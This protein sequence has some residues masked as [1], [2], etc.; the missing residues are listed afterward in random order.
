MEGE[1]SD[2]QSTETTSPRRPLTDHGDIQCPKESDNQRLHDLMKI[3][4][5]LINSV[6][7]GPKE[8]DQNQEQNVV[9]VR[10]VK[11]RGYDSDSSSSDS[12]SAQVGLLY[13]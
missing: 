9:R 6:G 2:T 3:T 13:T 4:N 12:D 10:K 1:I 8:G 7:G 5:K 11:N